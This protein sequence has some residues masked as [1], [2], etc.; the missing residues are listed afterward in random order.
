LEQFLETQA[1]DVSR[2]AI[3]DKVVGRGSAFLIVRLGVRNVHAVLLSRLGK[4]VL[5]RAAVTC[6]WDTLVDEIECGTEGLL[7][8]VTDSQE[9]YRLLAERAKQALLARQLQSRAE[10]ERQVS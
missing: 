9:A 1:V 3:R 4:D 5:D 6:T 8:Q 2:A 10:T 7:R